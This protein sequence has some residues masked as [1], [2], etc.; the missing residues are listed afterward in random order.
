MTKKELEIFNKTI[1]EINGDL[2]NNRGLFYEKEKDSYPFEINNENIF[3]LIYF[4]IKK[5]IIK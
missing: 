5:G 1:K 4:L 2:Q 3:V